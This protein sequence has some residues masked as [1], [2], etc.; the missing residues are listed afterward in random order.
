MNSTARQVEIY[1]MAPVN[2]LPAFAV[3]DVGKDEVQS[4]NMHVLYVDL[5]N[6]QVSFHSPERFDGPDYLGEWDGLRMSEERIIQFC[7][8]VFD[9]SKTVGTSK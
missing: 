3:F 5:P 4:F 9:C 1:E 2:G 6:G 7:Q 8:E